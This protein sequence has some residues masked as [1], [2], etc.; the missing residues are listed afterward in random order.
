VPTRT[1]TDYTAVVE[2]AETNEPLASRYTWVVRLR[3]VMVI[4]GVA[5]TVADAGRQAGEALAELPEP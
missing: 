4:G 2:I 1:P 3:G 5:D